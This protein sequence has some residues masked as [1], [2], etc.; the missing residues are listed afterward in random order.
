MIAVG[1]LNGDTSI[2]AFEELFKHLEKIKVGIGDDMGSC[3]Y[4]VLFYSVRQS[5]INCVG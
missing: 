1:N 4:T 5:C 3:S 2:W